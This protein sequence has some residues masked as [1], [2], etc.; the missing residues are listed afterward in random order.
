MIR[1]LGSLRTH[2][3]D[4]KLCEILKNVFR[5]LQITGL[6]G[7]FSAYLT[8]REGL[9]AFAAG[10]TG[11]SASPEPT[12]NRV[13]CVGTSREILAYLGALLKGAGYEVLTSRYVGEAMTL[14]KVMRP[15]LIICGAGIENLPTGAE[16]MAAFRISSPA[17]RIMHLPPDFAVG[18]AGQAGTAVLDEVRSMLHT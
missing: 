15:D 5:V 1:T 11:S 12:R 8:E 4:L 9:D 2:G 16:A 3:G 18:E 17:V 6:L 13:L 7:V 10:R 14:A